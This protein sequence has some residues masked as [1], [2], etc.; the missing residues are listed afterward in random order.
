[1]SRVIPALTPMGR[2]DNALYVSGGKPDALY[3]DGDVYVTGSVD[4]Q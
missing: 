4:C 1:M 3:V 2:T